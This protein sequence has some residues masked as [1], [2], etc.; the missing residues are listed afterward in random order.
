[1]VDNEEVCAEQT[2]ANRRAIV[3]RAAVL[4]SFLAL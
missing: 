1:V 2:A 4:I 3:V